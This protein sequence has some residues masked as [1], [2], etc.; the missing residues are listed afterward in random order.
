M[1][2]SS[3]PR[4]CAT[5]FPATPFR[6]RAGLLRE[7]GEPRKDGRP[8]GAHLLLVLVEGC[9][10]VAQARRAAGTAWTEW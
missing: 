5:A 2:A 7:L 1:V 9:A 4:A 8:G 6:C 3:A 10:L